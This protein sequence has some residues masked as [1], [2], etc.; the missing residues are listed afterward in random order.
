VFM[1]AKASRFRSW[2]VPMVIVFGLGAAGFALLGRHSTPALH[3]AINPTPSKK[4][5]TVLKLEPSLQLGL[6]GMPGFKPDNIYA[7]DHVGAFSAAVAG[8]PARVYVPDGKSNTLSVIDPKTFKVIATYAVD[9]EPQHVVPA[10]DLK[11]L[12]VVNDVGNTITPINPRTS[13]LGKPIPIQDPYNL[14][15]TPDGQ[16][17]IIV[18]EYQRRLDFFDP[19]TWQKRSSL[20][21]PCK[22]INHMD[23]SSDG[24]FILAA[25]EFSGDLVKIDLEAKKVIGVLHVGGMPQDVKLSPDGQVF[26]VA[27]MMANGLHVVDAKTFNVLEFIPTG[28]GTHGLYPSRDAKNLYISNRGEGSISVLEFATRKLIAKWRIPG[29]GSPD[30]GSVSADG[31]QLWLAGRNN[32]EIYVFDTRLGKLEQRIKVGRGPHGLTFF[33]QPGRYSLGHTGVYR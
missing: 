33:P 28:K 26:Y 16:S 6:P 17:A 13:T 21:V 11:T 4:T 14:Y 9:K 30:M 7:F 2:V 32:G 27:D 12:Y 25:C 24:R 20:S 19:H 5:V 10:Y 1:G 31:T 3:A 18:A 23:F 22:G 15:F 8:I 29:G